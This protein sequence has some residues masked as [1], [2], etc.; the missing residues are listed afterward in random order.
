MLYNTDTPPNSPVTVLLWPVIFI[1]IAVAIWYFAFRMEMDDSKANWKW[2]AMV[3]LAL[4][5]VVGFSA[6]RMFTMSGFSDYAEA[7]NMGRKVIYSLYGA[8]GLPVLALL[9]IAG[10]FVYE[11]MSRNRRF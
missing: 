4:S 11:R 8:A 6:L 2:F 9:A 1:G 7:N 5:F 3:P 10:L